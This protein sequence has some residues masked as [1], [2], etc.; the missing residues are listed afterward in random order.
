MAQRLIHARIEGV[1][2]LLMHNPAGLMKA[3]STTG[4]R[5]AKRIPTPME[6]ATAGL[7]V[8]HDEPG[9][10]ILISDALRE[11]CK[12]AA[13][14]YRDPERKGRS[15]LTRRFGASVFDSR[16]EFPLERP[17]GKPI[18][19]K[20]EDWEPFVKRVVV[21][22]Q[23]VMRSRGKITPWAANVEFE[24]DDQMIAPELIC[25]VINRAGKYP[26]VLDYRPGV[27]GPY[28]RFHVVAFE[29][30]DVEFDD[31]GMLVR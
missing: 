25:A 3:A 24:Y 22:R 16:L 9:R 21:Q 4:E 11:A 23:G 2:P 31:Q 28:G 5:A 30:E 29:G 14:D 27:G 1:S 6:E 13:S 7:Y 10:L 19:E 20:E 12:T 8:S 18:T 17:D 26:G 15:T